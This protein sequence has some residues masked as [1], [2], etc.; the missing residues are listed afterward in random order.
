MLLFMFVS[1][2]LSFIYSVSPYFHFVFV[3]LLTQICWS[4]NVRT[5]QNI[6]DQIMLGAGHV[7]YCVLLGMASWLEFSLASGWQDSSNYLFCY[8]GLNNHDAIKR[9]A[10]SSMA[11]I[12]KDDSFLAMLVDGSDDDD[13]DAVL[14]GTHSFR[15]FAAQYARNKGC[16]RDAVDVRFRWKNQ[17][18]QDRYVQGIVPYED[19]HVA[20]CLCKGGPISYQV[21]KEAN[22]SDEW[23]LE[24]VVPNIAR[25]YSKKVALVL[26]HALLWR[27]MDPVQSKVLPTMMVSTVRR[28]V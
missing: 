19:A 2:F 14:R 10:S 7:D 4:K 17:R 22:I 28:Q 25:K 1:F 6:H 11:A 27:C 26:G 21:K 23:I 24:F 5:E 18:M 12:L 16:S 8:D 13:Q 3:S 9:A 15:K 20:E